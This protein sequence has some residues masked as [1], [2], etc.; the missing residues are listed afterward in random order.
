M[1]GRYRLTRSQ[2]QLYDSF[3]ADG[4]HAKPSSVQD[5]D[6]RKGGYTGCQNA[7]DRPVTPKHV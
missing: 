1:C 5:L 3:D 4:A 7:R 6:S 2:K